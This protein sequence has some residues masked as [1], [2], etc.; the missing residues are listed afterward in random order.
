M[1][2]A[3]SIR[4][5]FI[6]IAISAIAT[7][8]IGQSAWATDRPKSF[9][10]TWTLNGQHASL[11]GYEDFTVPIKLKIDVT[12]SDNNTKYK[13][14]YGVVFDANPL[15]TTNDCQSLGNDGYRIRYNFKHEDGSRFGWR[16][17]SKKYDCG[18][19]YEGK[20]SGE[21]RG[22]WD[23]DDRTL[24]FDLGVKPQIA[25]AWWYSRENLEAPIIG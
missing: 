24:Q 23:P 4:K 6:V 9:I 8:G 1:S 3:A 25:S 17:L 13:I 19:V 21:E 16:N 14:D 20:V 5:G 15:E 7:T 18:D 10:K 22:A 2:T 12:L 11:G